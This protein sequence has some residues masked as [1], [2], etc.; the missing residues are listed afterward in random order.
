MLSGAEIALVAL[1]KTRLEEL[2]REGRGAAR[3]VEK[4]RADPERFLA[5]VQV[6]ITVVGATA[7]AF[8]GARFAGELVPYV[9]RVPVL[10]PYAEELSLAAVVALVS[11]LSLVV[12]ELVPK[13]LA[14]RMPEGYALLIGRPLLWLSQLARPVVWFLTASSNVFLRLFGD[15]TSFTEARLSL[16]ELQQTVEEAS[17]VGTLDVRSGEIAS[18]ALAFGELVA[19]EVMMPRAR[20]RAVPKDATPEALLEA[21]RQSA[22]TRLPVYEGTIDGIVGYVTCREVLVAATQG[23]LAAVEELLRD[24]Y[25]V[26]EPMPAP[27]LLHE[28]R[29]RQLPLAFV[30]DEAGGVSGL[31]TLEDLVEELVGEIFEEDEDVVE[32]IR[33][34]PSGA[35]VV[36]G[37]VTVRDANRELGLE[38]PEGEGWTTVAGLVLHLAGRMPAA[39]ERYETED[40]ATLE[41]VDAS[42][43]R[44]RLVRVHPPAP[45]R[46]V[47]GDSGA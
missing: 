32:P 43:R 20:I 5:T 46:D 3:A 19:R 14:L 26:P 39:G 22:H 1:R 45:E 24:P 10:A 41:V 23:K 15:R 21:V 29:R 6:G 9:A 35:A 25:F 18:R 16:E 2:L 40:R 38:L 42:A 7:S 37:T 33:R 8:G 27:K 17:R 30:V 31:V 4:L 47:T 11:Y 34:E 12:G 13:S 36:A 44:V 28:L